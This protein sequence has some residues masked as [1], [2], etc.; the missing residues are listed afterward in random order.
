[1]TINVDLFLQWRTR[2]AKGRLLQ[3]RRCFLPL[4]LAKDTLF[5]QELVGEM[6]E[7][8]PSGPKV[9]VTVLRCAFTNENKDNQAIFLLFPSKTKQ[10]FSHRIAY[11][12]LLLSRAREVK[13]LQTFSELL[14]GRPVRIVTSN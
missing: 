13:D 1:M 14:P 2:R 10:I 11:N 7:I 6:E 4:F 9:S 3:K 12:Y 8:T 5:L